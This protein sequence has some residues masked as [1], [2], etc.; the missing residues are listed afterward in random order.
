M[1]NRLTKKVNKCI[2]YRYIV[3]IISVCS[4]F[5]VSAQQNISQLI[6]DVLLSNN[7]EKGKVLLQQITDSDIKNMP[8]STLLEYYYLAGVVA[9]END[10]FGEQIEYLT[11]A[12]EICETKLGINNNVFVYFEIIKALGEACEELG[13]DDEAILWYEEGIVKGLPYL[14]VNDETIQSYFYDIFNNLADIYEEKGHNDIAEYLRK[15]KIL[16]DDIGSFDYA[17]GLLNEAIDL[18]AKGK[19][20]EAIKLLDKAKGIFK[21]CG[22]KGEEMMQPLYRVYLLCY[23]QMGDTKSVD[24]L[25]RTKSKIIFYDDTISYLIDDMNLVISHYVLI[26]HDVKTAERYY[27]ILRKMI[28]DNNRQEVQAVCEI[29]R[30]LQSYKKVYSEIDS[31]ENIK[32]TVATYS[33]RWGITSLQQAN[34]LYAIQRNEDANKICLE[35]YKMSATLEDDPENLHWV[36]LTNLADYY[37]QCTDINKAEHYLKEQLTWL[38]S[39]KNPAN[40]EERGWIYNQLAVIYLKGECYKECRNM[41]VKAEEILLPIYGQQSDAYA[42]ILHNKGRLLQLEGKLDEAKQILDEAVKIQIEVN[43]KPFDRT[44]QYLE[45]V[46]HAIDVRL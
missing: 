34:L 9:M 45:E 7:L 20:D 42:T 40:A 18:Y 38:D 46:K 14:Q 19:A 39:K 35:I 41:L 17:D 21:E 27:H 1:H 4:A 44:I 15:S 33:Y 37:I 24:A 5:S 16:G 32:K 25:L 43:G 8:D 12:K 6:T 2:V 28:D 10:E 30:H 3:L 29:E 11:K 22:T 13:K 31:L 26:H 23:A 36:V